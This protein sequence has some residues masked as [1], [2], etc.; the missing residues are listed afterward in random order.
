MPIHFENE[1]RLGKAGVFFTKANTN[2]LLF[3]FATTDWEIFD[4]GFWNT[5]NTNW[6]NC[7]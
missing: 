6:N 3:C 2:V 4:G 1:I 7:L 5:I